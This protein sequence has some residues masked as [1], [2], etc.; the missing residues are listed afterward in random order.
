MC[1]SGPKSLLCLLVEVYYFFSSFIAGVPD[2]VASWTP[3][4]SA[5]FVSKLPVTLSPFD[6]WNALTSLS[7]LGSIIILFR[8]LGREK[9][10]DYKGRESWVNPPV[11]KIGLGK[12]GSEAE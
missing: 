2:V 8:P 11:E 10:R 9:V 7:Q 12:T 3:N 1:G 4:L 5:V 6:F